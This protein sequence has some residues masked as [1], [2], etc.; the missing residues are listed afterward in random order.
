[1]YPPS[2]DAATLHQ[3]LAAL[4]ETQRIRALSRAICLLT[5]KYNELKSRVEGNRKLTIQIAERLAKRVERNRKLTLR[6]ARTAIKGANL[7]TAVAKAAFPRLFQRKRKKLQLKS[8]YVGAKLTLLQQEVL[9]HLLEDEWT[10]AR[11][12][13]HMR[14]HRKT[15]YDHRS[16]ALKKIERYVAKQGMK[17]SAI[18]FGRG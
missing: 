1:M 17:A 7:A 15:I 6:T 18:R 14:K 16:A 10:V 12:A 5:D 13:R 11:I 4:D 9:M 2:V 8:Y 3:K